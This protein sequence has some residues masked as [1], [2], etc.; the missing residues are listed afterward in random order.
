MKK[1]LKLIIVKCRST[2]KL[3]V[4][5]TLH[6]SQSRTKRKNQVKFLFSHFFVVPQKQILIQS[7]EA[8]TRG[9]L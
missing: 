1:E 8:A 7:P 3:F 2:G 4:K 5:L 9:A 6:P